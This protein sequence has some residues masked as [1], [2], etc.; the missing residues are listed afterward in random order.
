MLDAARARLMGAVETGRAGAGVS[1]EALTVAALV[2]APF[3]GTFG[4]WL[5]WLTW[6]PNPAIWLTTA[7]LQG[8]S[9]LWIAGRRRAVEDAR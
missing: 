2:A 9:T 3:A 4:V 1:A 8:G 5:S 6:W 7:F